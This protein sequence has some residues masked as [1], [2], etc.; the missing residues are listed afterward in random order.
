MEKLNLFK[1]GYAIVLVFIA[2]TS[3]GSVIGLLWYAWL[4]N[5]SLVAVPAGWATFA[6]LIAVASLAALQLR[7]G[8]DGNG[9]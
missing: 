5:W 4:R 1:V 8:H 3:W 2:L 7:R 6:I 9:R